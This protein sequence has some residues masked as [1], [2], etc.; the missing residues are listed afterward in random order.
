MN[1][2]IEQ[3][4]LPTTRIQRDEDRIFQTRYLEQLNLITVMGWS[5][6]R[7]IHEKYEQLLKDLIGHFKFSKCLN[8]HFKYDLFNSSSLKYLFKII[9]A[10]NHA[11]RSGNKVT[12]YWSCNSKNDSEMVDMGL[13]L[14][15]I[16][17]FKFDISYL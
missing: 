6:T 4:G 9:K 14:A 3:K 10:L 16:S 11:H 5:I 1:L 17:D 8:I 15:N 13:D 7:D 2:A 12:V